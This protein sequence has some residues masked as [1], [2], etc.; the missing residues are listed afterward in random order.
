MSEVAAAEP[1][2][3]SL[4]GAR[5]GELRK[6]GSI[7]ASAPESSN[8]VAVA[9]TKTDSRD[10]VAP[11]ISGKAKDEEEDKL[12]AKP[13][14][15]VGGLAPLENLAKA[16]AQSGFNTSVVPRWKVSS[17]GILQRSSDSG[18]TWQAVPVEGVTFRA[19]ASVAAEVWAGGPAGV[20]YHSSDS[21]Q[22]WTRMNLTDH[23]KALT[24]DL[25]TITFTDLQHGQFETA[26]GELWITH[27]AGQTWQKQ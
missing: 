11:V 7:A 23:G 12:R 22:H 1:A 2:A 27:D 10:Q 9:D 14:M 18:Q 26:N 19:V 8:E 25:V 15:A 6:E 24:T 16:K 17:E 3:K 13:T 4:D 5:A 21:G 20:L